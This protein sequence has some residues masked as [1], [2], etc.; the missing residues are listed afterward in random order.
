MT[1]VAVSSGRTVFYFGLILVLLML[2]SCRAILWDRGA[3]DDSLYLSV[4][5]AA[6][7]SLSTRVSPVASGGARSLTLA[8][9]RRTALANNLELQL[10]RVEELT[11]SAIRDGNRKKMLPHLMFAGE[12]GERDNLGFSYSDVIG[13]E[14]AAPGTGGAGSTGV[15]NFSVAHERSTWRYNLELRWSPSDAALAYYLFKSGGND[16]RRA[17]F[18]KVRVA[19]QLIG[20]VESAFFRLLA[21]QKLLPLA[22]RL[23]SL[24]NTALKDT[25]HLYVKKM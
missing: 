1:R 13:Q 4:T 7:E 9:C 14:G 15:T 8:D 19:Q 25:E 12:L 23:K 21:L 18:Q 11:R 16:S 10:A 20:N 24:R 17:H 2:C 6:N 5:K 3:A 22:V